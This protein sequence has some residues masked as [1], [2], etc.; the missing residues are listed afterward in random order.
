MRYLSTRAAADAVGVAFGEAILRGLAP[1]GGLYVPERLPL[2]AAADFEGHE[3]PAAICGRLLRPFLEG[4]PLA[5]ALTEIC[6][7][8]ASFPLPLVGLPGTDAP[9]VL[10]LF[11]GPTAAF[12]DLGAR[13]LAACV[14]RIGRGDPRPLTVLVAT[15]GDTGSAVAAAFSGRPAVRVVLMYPA[16]RVS[17]RQ[18][19]LLSCW[20]DNV[21]S[22]EVE[23]SFDDCQRMAKE[24][25]A[26]PALARTLRLTSANSINLGRLLPQM[27]FYATASLAV[28]RETGESPGFVIPTGNLGNAF[29]CLLAREIGLPVGEILLAT[30]ANRSVY[31]YLADGAWRPRPA[32]PTLASAMD[33]G[34]PS[35]MERVRW[36]FPEHGRLARALA[37]EVVD[38]AAIRERIAGAWRRWHRAFCPH[39]ATALAAWE[40]LEPAARARPWVIVATA[41]A[42]K[43]ERIVEPLIGST[44][45]PPAA[46]RELLA[47]PARAERMAPDGRA[48]ARRLLRAA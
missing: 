40:R 4:D 26:D 21:L 19:R 9:R 8:A 33:V 31:D 43:F 28:R 15:S 12:K 24:A 2:V 22:L 20:D 38:D 42:A 25:F 3:T 47:R 17:P 23:G 11:H 10:E 27:L 30:N 29:A 36:L 39:T 5:G 13:F 46:M 18:S 37:A 7:E 6:E 35:N 48:L 44:V 1:D 32:V 14:G 16:G 34:D 45:D 41:H